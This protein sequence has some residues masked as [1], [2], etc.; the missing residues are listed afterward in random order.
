MPTQNYRTM[1]EHHKESSAGAG[2][3]NSFLTLTKEPDRYKAW[4]D[5]LVIH[6]VLEDRSP[7]GTTDTPNLV[8]NMGFGVLFAASHQSSTTTVD[9]ES[10]LLGENS[11]ISLRA[12]NGVAGTVKLPIQRS[13]RNNQEDVNEKDG[14]ITIWMKTPDVTVN[15]NI[16]MRFYVECYGRWVEIAGL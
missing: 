8:S 13:I 11:I 12:R 10:G 14:T 4:A 9:G 15:D 2:D 5:H 1:I 3:F 7:V 16:I 6:Y